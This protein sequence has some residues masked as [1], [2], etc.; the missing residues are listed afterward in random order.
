MSIFYFIDIKRN[1]KSTPRGVPKKSL[2]FLLTFYFRFAI[3]NG[4]LARR[5][6]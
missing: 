3:L 1:K 4:Q 2:K 6:M 5:S